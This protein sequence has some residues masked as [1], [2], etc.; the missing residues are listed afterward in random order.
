MGAATFDLYDGYA[1]YL[2]YVK[3]FR[4]HQRDVYMVSVDVKNAFDTIIALLLKSM[5]TARCFY[6]VYVVG[7]TR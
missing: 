4:K 1:M 2:P 7:F 5:V 3:R 6:L